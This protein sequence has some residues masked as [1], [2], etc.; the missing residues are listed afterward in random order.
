[1]KTS[2]PPQAKRY[3]LE[4]LSTDENPTGVG[5]GGGGGAPRGKKGEATGVPGA[6]EIL[7]GADEPDGWGAKTAAGLYLSGKAAN[8]LARGVEKF[9]PQAIGALTKAGKWFPKGNNLGG[10]MLQAIAGGALSAIPGVAAKVL[11]QWG[12]I[13]GANFFDANIGHIGQSAMKLSTEGGGRPWTPFVI[14]GQQGT[15]VTPYDPDYDLKKR[16][17]NVQRD[18]VTRDLDA[19]DAYRRRYLP[20]A[21]PGTMM[22]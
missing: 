20:S 7:F 18:A 8:S 22:S 21:P 11:R 2:I 12:E 1:M 5:S 17:Q 6:T 15:K 3:L 4:A 13:S 14:P 16:I 10:D 9:G 19:Y